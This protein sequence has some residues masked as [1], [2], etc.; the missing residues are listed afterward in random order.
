MKA[1]RINGYNIN[2]SCPVW[3]HVWVKVC[4]DCP[5]RIKNDNSSRPQCS[6]AEF[7]NN[8]VHGGTHMNRNPFDTTTSH[9]L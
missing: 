6:R 2:N 8:A 9:N 5:F 4:T 1:V 3:D 7:V